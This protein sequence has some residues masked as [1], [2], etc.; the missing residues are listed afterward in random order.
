LSWDAVE[1]LYSIRG[2]ELA[3]KAGT[4]LTIDGQGRLFFQSSDTGCT[5]NGTMALHPNLDADLYADLYDVSLTIE[6][7][8][9]AYAYLNN[10]FEGLSIL[11]NDS[12]CTGCWDDGVGVLDTPRFWLSMP[13]GVTALSFSADP[14]GSAPAAARR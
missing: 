6:G 7:C 4:V 9:G 5:G 10:R 12:G 3:G 2:T 8:V 14:V 11:D 13:A 1:G